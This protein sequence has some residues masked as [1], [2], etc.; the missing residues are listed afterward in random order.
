VFAGYKDPDV[1]VAWGVRTRS[2]NVEQHYTNKDHDSEPH[3]ASLPG[4]VHYI[5]IM[6]PRRELGTI[7]CGIL[8][9]STEVKYL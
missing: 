3:Y 4:A 7:T 9:T 1:V 5:C 2:L 8:H 6:P